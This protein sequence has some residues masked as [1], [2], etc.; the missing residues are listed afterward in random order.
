MGV[1]DE[2][3]GS[4]TGIGG[5]QVRAGGRGRAGGGVG[6]VEDEHQGEED[7]AVRARR[8]PWHTHHTQGH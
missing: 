3:A 1:R 6:V 8:K 7:A 5:D 4:V 2:L